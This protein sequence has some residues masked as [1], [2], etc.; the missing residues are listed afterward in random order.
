MQAIN[1]YYDENDH[2]NTKIV[3]NEEE[4]IEEESEYSVL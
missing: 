3:D 2:R 4:G 1:Y